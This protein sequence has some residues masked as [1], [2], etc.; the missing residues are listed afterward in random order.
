MQYFTLPYTPKVRDSQMELLR[1]IA[2]SMILIHHFLYH[3]IFP[4]ASDHL[5]L[6]L[7]IPQNALIYSG[8][9]LFVLIS[10][11]YGMK[12]TW[13]SVVKLALLILFFKLVNVALIYLYGGSV[14]LQKLIHEAILPYSG[15][16]YWF[17]SIY[18]LLMVT[19]PII[20]P[21]LKKMSLSQLRIL[22]GVLTFVTIFSC[23]IGGNKGAQYGMGYLQFL[24]LYVCGYYIHNETAFDKIDKY[25]FLGSFF[26]ICIID[27]ILAFFETRFLGKVYYTTILLFYLQH[28]LYSYFS[29]NYI[30]KI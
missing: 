29:A 10:G 15:I 19:V 3:G 13:K 11:Y 23:G 7:P 1:I 27:F 8:V 5:L 4:I 6:G 20:N 18:F 28:S 9:N 17:I 21:G 12:F 14:S 26:A 24:Y 30:S 2:M 22:V 16:Y 25:W